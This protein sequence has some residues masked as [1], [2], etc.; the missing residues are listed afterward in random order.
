M[1]AFFKKKR[2]FTICNFISTKFNHHSRSIYTV[3][4]HNISKSGNFLII[5]ST[6]STATEAAIGVHRELITLLTNPMMVIQ[7]RCN[8]IKSEAIEPIVFDPH[9][10]IRQK[11]SQNFPAEITL[12]YFKSFRKLDV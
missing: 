7:H 5:Q 8:T 10:Q 11:E 4:Q 6:I 12:I 2:A 9:S 3:A 1:A